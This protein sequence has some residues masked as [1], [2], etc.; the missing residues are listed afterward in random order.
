MSL[1]FSL[2]FVVPL[3]LCLCQ[4]HTYTSLL[5][6][7]PVPL[8]LYQYYTYTS[9]L[10][11]VPVPLC[12]CQYYTYTSLLFVVLSLLRFIL[13]LYNSLY[14]NILFYN[15]LHYTSTAMP[16]L[17]QY[18]YANTMPMPVPL[19]QYCTYASTTMPIPA[20]SLLCYHC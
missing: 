7:V 11:V 13:Y 19:C 5:F 4:Y 17:Y 10:F 8:C 15:N 12:L 20:S 14:Y 1:I 9:L 2:L 16:V 6:V 3:P 18:N